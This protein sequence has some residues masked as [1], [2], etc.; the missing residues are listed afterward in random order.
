MKARRLISRA[1]VWSCLLVGLLALVGSSAQAAVTHDYLSQ[2]TEVPSAG[3]HGETVPLP[4][5][6]TG[7]EAMAFDSG[8]LYV[9]TRE[10]TL[11]KFSVSGAFVSQF[12]QAPGLSYLYQG[13]AIGHSTGET[14]VYTAGDAYPAG[15]P[16]G[17]IAVFNQTGELQNV[18]EGADTPEGKFDCFE[19]DGEGGVAV[20][21]SSDLGDWASGDVYVAAP[22]E[23]V[24]DVFKPGVKGK[25]EYAGIQLTGISPSEPFEANNGLIVTVSAFNGEVLVADGYS[26]DIFKPGALLGQ[27]EFIGN[28]VSPDGPYTEPPSLAVDGSDG[29]IYVA[30]GIPNTVEEFD[31]EGVHIGRLSGEGTPAG[32]FTD[33]SS[34]AVDPSTH[35]VY[36]GD[37][38][39]GIYVFSG[40]MV[41]PDVTT[42][43]ASGLE[44]KGATLNG[45]VDLDEAGTAT[46]RFNWG[47]SPALGNILP[48]TEPVVEGK[49]PGP[50]Q[51]QASLSGLLQPDTTYYYRLEASNGNGT[52]PGE[53]FQDQTFT[54]PG[55]GLHGDSVSAVRA[56]SATFDAKIDPNNANVTYF[57]QY[58]TSTEYGSEAPSAPGAALG[59]GSGD[60]EVSQHVQGLQAA[61]VYHYRP[62]AISEL[63]PGSFETFYGPDQTFVT[64]VFNGSSQLPDER[65]WEMV[66]PPQKEGA[67][68]GHI[69]DE[70]TIEASADGS[71]FTDWAAAP[72]EAEPEGSDNFLD[73][74]FG[75]GSDGWV[76]KVITP[77]H[78][79]HT[80][81]VIN[82]GLEYRFFSED[83]SKGA[84]QP[85]G[86]FT[87]LSPEATGSTPYLRT[88]YVG[89][90]PGKPCTSAC[91]VPLAT[92]SNLPAGT[93]FGYEVDGKCKVHFCGPEILA[94]TPS[95]NHVILN[96]T[97]GSGNLYEWGN[98]RLT[99]IGDGGLASAQAARHTISTDGSRVVFNGS[100]EGL[101]GL[102]LR[103]TVHGQTTKLDLPQTGGEDVGVNGPLF[104]TASSDDSRIFFLDAERL[105]Q[106]STATSGE[107]DLYE[108]DLNA[109]LGNRL[110]DLTVDPGGHANVSFVLGASEDG[111]YV[112]FA[113]AGALADGASPGGCGEGS[114]L[115]N[116]Y[117]RHDGR[118]AFI[119]ALP[120]EDRADW[121]GD[122]SVSDLVTNHV[123]PDGVWLAFMSSRN[124]AG[125]DTDDALSGHP[126]E[127]VYLY[128][129]ETARLLCASCDPT[130]AR[131]IGLEA[132]SDENGLVADTIRAFDSTVWIASSVPAWSPNGEQPSP[133]PYQRYLSDDGRLFF[134]SD[135]AL[136]PGDVNGTQDV[137]EYEPAG[138]GD[139][140]E[141]SLTFSQRSGGCVALISS[142]TS[143][144]ESAFL[145]ASKDGSDVFFLTEAK[146]LPQDFDN[147]FDIYDAHECSAEVPCIASPPITPPPCETGDSCK[148]SPAPQPGVFGAPPSATFNGA[149]NVGQSP[150]LA[151]TSSR[152]LTRAQK[153]ARALKVCRT[154]DRG[155]QRLSL[156]C[157]RQARKSYAKK[158]A[159]KRSSKKSTRK[160]GH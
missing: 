63:R 67:E 152:S 70:G 137:Y 115:C 60:I 160:S 15:S 94:G 49:G 37:A 155:R 50:V 125:Y 150:S 93:V 78:T 27:Y 62:V 26:V 97:N 113:A 32:N 116:L 65:S 42:G 81:A 69:V 59:N 149:G 6:L 121:D 119:A 87:P 29:D 86:S 138:M 8:E 128:D 74:F 43:V 89:E 106:D 98:S 48:C 114:Q 139:C 41:I 135:D 22:E 126:D 9:S 54:T 77:S 53:S 11:D 92:T 134:D 154:R 7:V 38:E 146:L 147:A 145:E 109:P 3:P 157:E 4:G 140:K 36:I 61:T 118:T 35:H 108:Y 90:E 52:N 133:T 107:P 88:D 136:V 99:L 5:P 82:N 143:S 31:A 83:L 51:V 56:E 23:G 21:N 76:S 96:L 103:D 85:F 10:S 2:I 34:V 28:L 40:N 44:P 30:K 148:A 142:G 71:A 158:K 112:Y 84:L 1:L 39:K 153:L 102:L 100:S 12:A 47:T 45:T 80:N 20:D 72:T 57:F 95:L 55:V 64:Q 123:S 68:L 73:V 130:G 33:A 144:R 16:E 66:S 17:A 25:E 132:H 156:V 131:P 117:V 159:V 120:Y 24:I 127:E 46:C 124:L 104:M 122:S 101:T 18:W 129:A 151:S 75:R 141:S 91:Y 79:R 13:L 19:C 105:T 14:E 111:S 110:T 58:G